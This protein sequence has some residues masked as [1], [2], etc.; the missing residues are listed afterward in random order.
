M[1]DVHPP[2]THPSSFLAAAADREAVA[3]SCNYVRLPHISMLEENFYC[4]ATRLLLFGYQ[5]ALLQ[6]YVQQRGELQTDAVIALITG[7]QEAFPP[8]KAR[9]R[10]RKA[11]NLLVATR[12][13]MTKHFAVTHPEIYWLPYDRRRQL[14][15]L[16]KIKENHVLSHLNSKQRVANLFHRHHFV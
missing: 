6:A 4:D 14:W 5:F 16:L 12:E 3:T 7:K 1:S 13:L 15:V 9:D 2:F 8:N 11:A 10:Q